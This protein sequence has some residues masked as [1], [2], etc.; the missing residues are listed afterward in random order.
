[1]GI[2]RNYM[3]QTRKPEG[4]LGNMMI[5]GMNFGHAGLANWGMSKLKVKDPEIIADLGCGGGSN[6]K[7]LAARYPGA[8]ITGV[9]YSPLSVERSSKLNSKLIES[10]R[11]KVIQ[12]NV[13]ALDL[14]E[15]RYDLATAFETIYFWPGL[16]RCFAEASRILKP[17]GVF[18]IVNETDG[19][20][21][22]SMKYED[23]IEGMKI[24]TPEQISSALMDAGFAETR[25]Y[26]QGSKPW[27]TI[28]ACKKEGILERENDKTVTGIGA[29]GT[30]YKNWVP[31]GTIAGAAAG[32]AVVAGINAA[33]W[34]CLKLDERN[35][36][37]AVK[38]VLGMGLAAAASMTTW[39]VMAYRVFSYDGKRKLSKEIIERIAEHVHI[40][41]GGTGL[42]VGCGS[43]ALT[44]AC[45]KLNP[46]AGMVGLDRWGAEY[47]S[48]S[49]KLCESNATAEGADN[50]SFRQGDAVK[51]DFPDETFDA[52]TSNYVYHNIAGVNK[53]QLLR[54]TLR[55]LKKGG[56][57][58]IHDIMSKSRYGDMN[59]FVEELRA[60][61]YEEVNLIPT[62]NGLFMSKNEAAYMMLKGSALLVGK[63]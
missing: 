4:F 41:E 26:R 23:I 47:A 54:E 30:D 14:P 7:E 3:N 49:K 21:G 38:A 43:G 51:L 2:I 9:D 35:A 63:K 61:G 24:Y 62:D 22:I 57:F 33:T 37:I 6:I 19:S 17:D 32:T 13:S 31:K 16:E 55:V 58:A 39:C 40:P 44:I 11:C 18:M 45:A 8:L 20:D 48:F 29:P 15:G 25:T 34:R 12:G 53:Q 60:E 56:T 10:G 27:I 59:R 42:D 52:V 36:D 50:V 5:T 46:G 28:I 1:M